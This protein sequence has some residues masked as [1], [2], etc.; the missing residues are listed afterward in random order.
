MIV[1]TTEVQNNFGKYLKLTEN[2]EIIITRNGKKVAKLVKYEKNDEYLIK[3]EAADYHHNS[4]KM[5][6]TYDEFKKITEDSENRYEYIDGCLYLMAS[7]TVKHQ[8]IV[9]N[10]LV[11]FDNWFNDNICEPFTSPFDVT[12]YKGEEIEENINVVQPDILVICDQENIDEDDRYQG[13]PELVVEIL[14]KTTKKHDFITKLELYRMTGINEYW[15]VNPFTEEIFIF[16][17]K[18]GEIEEIKSYKKE[19]LLRSLTCES[20][21]IEVNEI[22]A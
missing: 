12:L 22:F 21:K 18:D 5:K 9:R 20:L 7:P 11:K 4:K 13:T 15:I 19:E 3:E 14:S 10:L 8:R 17:F 1:T 2:E 6:V 16:L